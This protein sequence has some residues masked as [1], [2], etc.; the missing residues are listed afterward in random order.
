[1]GTTR[2][3]QA[4]KAIGLLVGVGCIITGGYF[5][6]TSIAKQSGTKGLKAPISSAVK[7]QGQDAPKTPEQR[8]LYKVPA[9]HPRE[10]VISKLGVDAIVLPMGTTDNVLNAPASA[11]DVGWYNGSALPTTQ[12]SVGAM[13]IDGHV[14]DALNSP[15]VF[16]K[17]DTLLVGDTLTIYDGANHQYDFT[18]LKVDQVPLD[19]VDMGSMVKS[20][21]PG[22]EGLNLI[23]CGGTYNAREKTYND[24]V[25]V[26]A[27]ED[28]QPTSNP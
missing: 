24:R 19:K 14:N 18:V 17:L 3:S 22:R 1:M 26:Y 5:L 15:G 8:S 16:Y 12:Q 9:N 2:R 23:T 27:V 25:L 20:L 10:L 4:F 6:A 13:L 28:S 21:L 7:Q 11:W